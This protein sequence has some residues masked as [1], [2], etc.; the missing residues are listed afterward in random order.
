[1]ADIV[2][3]PAE[4]EKTINLNSNVGITDIKVKPRINSNFRMKKVTGKVNDDAVSLSSDDGIDFNRPVRSRPSIPTN[5]YNQ[6]DDDEDYEDDDYGVQSTNNNEDALLTNLSNPMKRRSDYDTNENGQ[7]NDNMSH[8]S[9]HSRGSD[10]DGNY[11]EQKHHQQDDMKRISEEKQE[12]LYKFYRLE[13]K[14]IKSSRR[15]TMDSSLED[16]KIEYNKL[17][18][19]IEVEQSIKFQRRVL[20]ACVS[21]LE[22]MNKRYD[23]FDAKLDGWSESVMEGIEEYD[24]TFERLHEKYKSKGEMAPELELMLGLAGSAFMF[25]LTHTLFKAAMPNMA[26]IAKQNPQ[27][28]QDVAQAMMQ[29]MAGQK[30]PPSAPMKEGA[31][32]TSF[33][34][35]PPVN[36]RQEMKGPSFQSPLG[37]MP[38]GM[39]GM[40]GMPGG[41]GDLMSQLG[42]LGDMVQNM[43]GNMMPPQQQNFP[44]QQQMN[45]PAFNQAIANPP[46]LPELSSTREPSVYQDDIDMRSEITSVSSIDFGNPQKVKQISVNQPSKKRGRRGPQKNEVTI[47][48]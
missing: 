41:M 16:M 10:N 23:P 28:M 48:L 12:M 4:M 17:S 42:P 37:G 39:P 14:G 43:V 7:E 29:N 35:P 31:P 21:G 6:P 45:M 25:H 19:Q 26:D 13:Q 22:F 36:P 18:K 9:M 1:M 38:G 34:P 8:M 40:P 46:A 44:P 3:Q 5:P 47:Q 15:F 27:L 30:I 32:P 11:E 20:M 33:G 2:V 24:G